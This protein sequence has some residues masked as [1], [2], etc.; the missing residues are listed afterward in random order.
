MVGM[1]TLKH[2]NIIKQRATTDKD[3]MSG[4]LQFRNLHVV[5]MTTLKHSIFIKQRATTDENNDV[6]RTAVQELKK[7][8]GEEVEEKH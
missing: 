6:R 4:I 7:W 5:G 2:S 3:S 8:W 1:T